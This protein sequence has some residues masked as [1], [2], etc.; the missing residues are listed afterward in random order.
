MYNTFFEKRMMLCN[1]R[2][3]T[4]RPGS[5]EHD[6]SYK[7]KAHTKIIQHKWHVRLSGRWIFHCCWKNHLEKIQP[8]TKQDQ[9]THERHGRIITL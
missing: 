8:V 2:V 1:Q 9:Y 5:D 7:P 6:Q 4:Q 3:F